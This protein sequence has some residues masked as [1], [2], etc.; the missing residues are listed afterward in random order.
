MDITK[1]P[2]N[3]DWQEDWPDAQPEENDFVPETQG[4]E[5]WND[6]IIDEKELNE[7]APLQAE[8]PKFEISADYEEAEFNGDDDSYSLV[9]VRAKDDENKE[10]WI[11]VSGIT[12]DDFDIETG[13]ETWDDPGVYPSGAGG[14]RLPSY[15]YEVVESA[16]LPPEK[17]NDLVLSFSNY[18]ADTYTRDE[19][20]AVLGVSEEEFSKIEA[21]AKELGFK[22]LAAIGEEWIIDHAE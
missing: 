4:V 1:H 13:T 9:L 8:N 20:K 12:E 14:Y 2:V 3:W 21:Q 10:I 5:F 19:A 18:E 17:L 7:S 15:S 11:S 22:V 16:Y 6:V